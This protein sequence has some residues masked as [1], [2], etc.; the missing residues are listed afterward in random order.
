MGR[1]QKEKTY[2]KSI[3]VNQD[4]KEFLESLENANIFVLQL[5]E[6]TNEFKKFIA[7]KKSDNLT[8]SL[9]DD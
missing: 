9:F 8:G 6:D 2:I 5:L 3:R 7:I 1:K 4:I